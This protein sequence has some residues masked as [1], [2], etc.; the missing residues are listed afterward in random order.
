MESKTLTYL[1]TRPVPRWTLFLGRWAASALIV[2]VLLGVSAWWIGFDATSMAENVKLRPRHQVPDGFTGRFV[3][4][5]VLSGV[6]YTTMAAGLSTFMKRA[7]IVGL[8]YAFVLEMVVGNMPGS[9]MRLSIQYYL[10]NIILDG[11]VKAFSNFGP[12]STME[13]I[14][15]SEALLRLGLVLIALLVSGCYVV[16]RRQYVLSS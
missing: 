3:V 7:I 6:L 14:T 16:Q 4:A 8:S 13:L 2:A 11:E 12:F 15:P 1:F 9:T 5:S 10:R